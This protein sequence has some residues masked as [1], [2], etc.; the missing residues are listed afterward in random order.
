MLFSKE[1][2]KF[3]CYSEMLHCSYDM[4]LGFTILQVFVFLLYKYQKK[5]TKQPEYLKWLPHT[6]EGHFTSA[7]T[8]KFSFKYKIILF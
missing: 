2:Q 8:I 1:N 3:T 5:T 7:V 4:M 6:S